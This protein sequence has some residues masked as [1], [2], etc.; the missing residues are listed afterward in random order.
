MSTKKVR[1]TPAFLLCVFLLDGLCEASG[2][3]SAAINWEAESCQVKHQ[4]QSS[5]RSNQIIISLKVIGFS[6]K[7]GNPGLSV[8]L[9]I[10]EPDNTTNVRNILLSFQMTSCKWSLRSGA[11]AKY[12]ESK[13]TVSDQ[14]F[15]SRSISVLSYLIC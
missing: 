15:K 3:L 1:F 14:K 5:A 13:N 4:C 7:Y 2:F 9:S 8:R 11:R 12:R 10:S 6:Q